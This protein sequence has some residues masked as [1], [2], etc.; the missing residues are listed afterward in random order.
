MFNCYGLVLSCSHCDSFLTF[1]RV[2]SMDL[3]KVGLG[4]DSEFCTIKYI[5]LY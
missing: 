5:E 3:K 2:G 1:Q 4:Q